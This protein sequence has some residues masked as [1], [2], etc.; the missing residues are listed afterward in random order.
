VRDICRFHD[1]LYRVGGERGVA[2]LARGLM[3][4]PVELSAI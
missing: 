2:V 1:L 4:E 3:G